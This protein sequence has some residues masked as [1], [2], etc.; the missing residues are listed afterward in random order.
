LARSTVVALEAGKPGLAIGAVIGVL[1]ASGLQGKF[2]AMLEQDELGG[3]LDLALVKRTR[4]RVI[5]TEF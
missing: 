4:R 1:A 5:E 2:S 3:E